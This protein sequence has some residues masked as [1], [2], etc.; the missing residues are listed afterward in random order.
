MIE[1][2]YSDEKR[3]WIEEIKFLE[4]FLSDT[5]LSVLN[6]KDCK[7]FKPNDLHPKLVGECSKKGIKIIPGLN[8]NEGKPREHFRKDIAK[9]LERRGK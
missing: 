2:K 3:L 4:R 9:E 6:C 5:P 1:D 7:H 8:C